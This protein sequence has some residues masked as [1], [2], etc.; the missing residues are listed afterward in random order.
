ME[1]PQEPP[2]DEI[3]WRSPPIAQSMGGIHTNSGKFPAV[4]LRLSPISPPVKTAGPFPAEKNPQKKTNLPLP[5]VLPY[6]SHSPFYDQTSNNATLTTQATY[7]ASMVHI[8]QTREAFEARLRTMQGLEFMVAFEPPPRTV[9]SQDGSENVWVIRKQNRRKR[10]G[11]AAGAAE[12]EVTVLGSYFVVNENIYMAPSVGNVIGSKMFL[13][14]ASSLPIFA[15]SLG[16]TYVPPVPKHP[17]ASASTQPSQASKESTPMPDANL[18]NAKTMVSPSASR[19]GSSYKD[20][21]SLAESFN[22]SLRYGNEYMDENPLV[23]EPG[24]FILSSTHAHAQALNQ[25]AQIRAAQPATRG[26]SAPT[27][28]PI[29]TSQARKGSKGGGEKS[30]FPPH[31]HPRVWFITSAS[32]PLPIRLICQV[33]GHGDFVAAGVHGH[34]LEHED[35]QS[36]AFRAL[37]ADMEQAGYGPRLK[38]IRLD[39]RC[40]ISSSLQE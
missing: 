7:N 8:L 27:P 5:A 29:S 28:Q 10:Q 30:P 24:A 23:G 18:R 12:D 34:V 37:Q 22:L 4:P 11:A 15:P 6:F 26:P 13:S 33:L 19:P 2:L 35:D 25:A 20:T 36:R 32:S 17:S 1:G 21:L 38:V 3:Q 14:T 39:A 9:G 31:A 16:Y 40:G